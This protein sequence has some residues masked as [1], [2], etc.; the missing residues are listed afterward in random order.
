[1]SKIEKPKRLAPTSDT[2]R[3]IYLK[4]GNQCA[5]S[6][7]R[8]VMINSEGAFI[9]QICHIEAA[10]PGG[11]RF[12][13]K[14]SNEDRRKASNLLLMCYEHHV[15]TNDVVAFTVS[16]MQQIKGEHEA[17][18]SDI[19]GKM[20]ASVVDHTTLSAP[21]KATSLQRMN[22]VLEWTL[23]ADELTAM[24]E[25]V[26]ELADRLSKVPIPARKLFHIIVSRGQ[27]ESL[28]GLCAPIPEIQQVTGL[29]T[30]ELQGFF[31]ILDKYGLTS[32]GGEGD[33]GVH[34]VCARTLP[35]KWPFWVDVK[36]LTSKTTLNLSE[37]I[38][39]LNFSVLD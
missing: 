14:Q 22:T 28:V 4:S 35:S 12:N 36:E 26:S 11:E 3:G 18:F 6:G 34:L 39:D 7:C 33:F 15:T 9:G 37:L 10:E 5:F 20:L 13:P 25:D 27:E 21:K 23:T 8:Q 24:I 32:D 16:R 17:K 2:L 31:A 19:V 30:S 38:V 29:T 1:M